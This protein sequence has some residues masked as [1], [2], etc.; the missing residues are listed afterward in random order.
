[1]SVREIQMSKLRVLCFSLSLDGFAGGPEQSLEHP[2]GIG[3][4]VR[5]DRQGHARRPQELV[6][7]SKAITNTFK[8]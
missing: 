7:N 6:R 2:N 4:L 3:G 8:R 1:M 5:G